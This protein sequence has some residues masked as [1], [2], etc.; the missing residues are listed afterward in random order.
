MEHVTAAP[1]DLD[2]ACV[3]GKRSNLSALT[4]TVAFLAPSVLVGWG[5]VRHLHQ[6][7]ISCLFCLIWM[8]CQPPLAV[9][10]NVIEIDDHNYQTRSMTS[11]PTRGQ[12]IPS[13]LN[14]KRLYRE[15]HHP[16]ESWQS[17][18]DKLGLF[19]KLILERHMPAKYQVLFDRDTFLECIDEGQGGGRLS[20]KVHIP[21]IR[22][23]ARKE[24]R[25]EAAHQAYRRMMDE[26]A[27]ELMISCISRL[28]ELAQLTI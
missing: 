15:T 24:N 6:D 20:W 3:V 1:F 13:Q 5:D 2:L 18:I 9:S 14:I 25:D 7:I 4:G 8:V 12:Q 28:K 23:L 22:R 26:R 10:K 11:T 21:M 27:P 17:G 19:D 16:L